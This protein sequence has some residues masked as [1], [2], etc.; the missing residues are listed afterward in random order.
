MKPVLICPKNLV[1]EI[2]ADTTTNATGTASA[3]DG[4]SSVTV[5][6]SDLVTTNC[7][8]TR[9]IERT[10]T[11]TDQCGNST[12]CVQT[13]TVTDTTPPTIACST[14]TTVA[15]GDAWAFTQPVASDNGGLV[16]VQPLTTVTNVT[17]QTAC[18]VTRTWLAIDACGNTNICQQTIELTSTAPPFLKLQWVNPGT[19]MLS[20][21]ATGCQVESSDSLISPNWAAMTVTPL[22]INGQNTIQFSPVN[23]RKFYRLRKI[24]P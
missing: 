11:A 1:L 3:Q 20:W 13:I 6:Y 23:T 17:S 12:N 5:R 24:G 14:K 16:T 2:P 4:C 22:T 8:N 9:V 19:L 10:W 7:G 15:S 18:N 21:S